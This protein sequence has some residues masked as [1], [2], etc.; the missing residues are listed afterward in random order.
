MVGQAA[1]VSALSPSHE[2]RSNQGVPPAKAVHSHSAKEWVG[3]VGET[4]SEQD[5]FWE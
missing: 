5:L 4:D 3:N 2:P 1:L